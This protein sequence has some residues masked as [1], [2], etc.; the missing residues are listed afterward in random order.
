MTHE[1]LIC[2]SLS[3][4]TGLINTIN[5]TDR[6]IRLRYKE[7]NMQV[8]LVHMKHSRVWCW[9]LDAS[10]SRWEVS[11]KFWNVVLEKDVEDQLGDY[12]RNVE[13]LYTVKEGR[14]AHHTTKRRRANWCS[15]ILRIKCLL[16][17]AIEGK[18][19]WRIDV[20]G[21][22]GRRRKHLL[23]DVKEKGRYRELKEEAVDRTLWRTHFGSGQGGI[24]CKTDCSMNESAQLLSFPVTGFT[25]EGF[26]Y[27]F[28][29]SYSNLFVSI[30]DGRL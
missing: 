29:P 19:E 9:N 7:E 4:C 23:D 25:A 28:R 8:V 17:H 22:R 27:Y 24:C 13:V 5:K 30:K 2:V 14:N 11:W 26:D 1:S 15:H 3:C 21:R 6:Q 20:T 18:I 16:K 12:V 10:E